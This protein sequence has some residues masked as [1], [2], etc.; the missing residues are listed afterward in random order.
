MWTVQRLRVSAV[1]VQRVFETLDL[2]CTI[3]PAKNAIRL[4]DV[5]GQIDFSGVS[6]RYRPEGPD[7]LKDVSFTVRPG[8]KVAIV[9]LSGAGKTTIF[10]LLLRLYEPTAGSI[11]VDG[12]DLR[13]LDLESYLANVGVVLQENF[14]FSA[15]IRDNIL[16]G[17]INASEEELND[18]VGRAGLW[19]TIRALPRGLDTV[20]L[21]GG[22][23]SMG[24]KQRIGIARTLIRDPKILL[25]DEPTSLLDPRTEEDI[26]AQL[27][28]IEE[29]KTRLMIAHHISFVGEKDEIL[30]MHEGR[31]VQRG[32]Q[33]ELSTSDGPYKSLC[34]A[35]RRRHFV[36]A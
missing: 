34:T 17:N 26:L 25:L 24:Q 22:N 21:E 15:S 23:L 2:G 20:L 7:V 36:V 32:L 10:N 19:S 13:D 30:V 6:F 35:D 12:H 8:Q 5:R 11:R 29:D 33:A 1:P 14:I 9:G 27:A 31:L 28:S 18:V 3:Q 16:F 4:R